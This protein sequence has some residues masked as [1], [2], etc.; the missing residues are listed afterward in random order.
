MVLVSSSPFIATN[1]WKEFASS[2]TKSDTPWRMEHAI[3]EPRE[4]GQARLRAAKMAEATDSRQI[5]GAVALFVRHEPVPLEG[6]SGALRS[7]PTRTPRRV[8]WRSSFDTNPY[9]E[10]RGVTGVV[11]LST[12]GNNPYSRGIGPRR[13]PSYKIPSEGCYGALQHTFGTSPYPPEGWCHCCGMTL[14]ASSWP[15]TRM[16]PFACRQCL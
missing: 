15:G 1:G 11:W 12:F 5:V 14:Y 7:T 9:P 10:K 6:C 3:A 8:L 2:S 13:L 4:Y 16:R